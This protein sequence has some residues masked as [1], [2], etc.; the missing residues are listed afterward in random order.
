MWRSML[1]L[2]FVSKPQLK[3]TNL[4][5]DFFFFATKFFLLGSL[6]SYFLAFFE[7]SFFLCWSRMWSINVYVRVNRF[8]FLHTGHLYLLSVECFS[9][10]WAFKDLLF[11]NSLP[12]VPHVCLEFAS[13]IFLREAIVSLVWAITSL[14]KIKKCCLSCWKNLIKLLSYFSPAHTRLVF[15][16]IFVQPFFCDRID[17]FGRIKPRVEY[18]M[19]GPSKW[20]Y[21][22]PWVL[23]DL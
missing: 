5:V 23:N 14:E 12:H 7:S 16:E 8:G 15:M 11:E 19:V 20:E 10:T 3:H 4:T 13:A 18:G 6:T 21:K 17:G 2:R 9:S 22:L 1:N